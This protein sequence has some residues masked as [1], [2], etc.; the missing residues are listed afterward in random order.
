ME[1]VS[2][3]SQAS[4]TLDE[5]SL[6]EKIQHLEDMCTRLGSQVHAWT[7]DGLEDI[8]QF[9]SKFIEGAK[10]DEDAEEEEP[11]D[12]ATQQRLD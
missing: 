12:P 3:A 10:E 1:S 6:Q 4:S 2:G 9:T 7:N 5:A 11:L 8:Y